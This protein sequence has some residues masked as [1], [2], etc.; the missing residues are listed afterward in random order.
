MHTELPAD[1]LREIPTGPMLTRTLI[2]ITIKDYSKLKEMYGQNFVDLLEKELSDSLAATAAANKARNMRVIRPASGKA[3]FIVPQ[4]NNP[5]DIAYEYKTQAQKDME[6]TML[7]HTGLGIDLGMGFAPIPVAPDDGQWGAALNRA[8]NAALRMESRPLNMNDL[9]ITSRFNTILV[10]GWVSAHYQPILDF[11]T[12]TILGWEAL[13]RGPEGSAFRSPVMLFQTAEE[14]GRLFALEKLCREAAIRNVGELKDGQKLFLNIHPKTMADPSFSPGQTLDLMD[15]YGLTPDNVVFEITEQHSVQDFDLFYRALA[16]YR[17]QGFQIAVDD[18]GAGYSGLTLIAELQPDYIKLD[19]SL[20]D[21]IHKDPVKRALVETTA[22]FADKIGSRIIGEGIE[23]RDQAICLKNI[24]VHCGQGYFLARPAAPKPDVNE[25]CRHLKTVGDISNNIICSPPVGDLAK[26]PHSMEMSCLVASAHEFFRK[27][28]SFTN[29]VVVRDNVP[30]GLV[31]E[32]HLNRQ[33]SSQFGIALYHKRSIDTVMDKSPLI[34]DADMPV[35]QAARTAMKRE[36]IKTY[37]DIIVTKK[38]LLYGV[39]TVQDLLNVL[40]KIQVEMAKGTNP[41]TGLPG[42]VA[43]EQ[44]VESRIKQKRQFSIIYGDLDHFKV[45][46]DTYG[47]KN[48]DRIIKLA[49]DIMSWATRKHA[50]HDARLCHIG[51]DDFVLITPPDSVHN[52]CKSITRCFGRLVKSCY[53]MEDKERG[54][55]LAKGR[56]DKERKYPLVT[57]SLG[58]IEID[59]PCSLMEIG[60]RAAHI[61]KYAK[62]IPGNSVAIDRRPAIGKVEEAVCN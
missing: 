3:A 7:R 12:D 53:C 5:A 45:Y 8:L 1:I 13:A 38:G 6:P 11:R 60:E 44:E 17:S 26:A 10:Q 47:F 19:K 62:S 22:T 40:A 4:D 20:I 35:E 46:N 43:I 42:N 59:G 37:D 28:D 49:A 56:D 50:P 41:L 27:N 16:H 29:I 31:M 39:V 61:K 25:E 51:G 57:I 58:V 52:L 9:S 32:Y 14:L 23:T 54:W 55:I 15:K 24:G 36:H 2:L 33:L 48:G 30:K 21:D 34:V 18:A